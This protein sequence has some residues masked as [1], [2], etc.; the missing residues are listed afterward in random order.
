M[1]K[2]KIHLEYVFEKV[3]KNILWNHLT[4]PTGLSDWFADDVSVNGSNIFIFSWNKAT[5]EA[6]CLS[7]SHLSYIRFKWLDDEDDTYYFE[8]RIHTVELTGDTALEITDFVEPDEKKETINLW[9][10]QI[11]I[12]RRTLGI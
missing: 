6:E 11:K 1:E 9:D 4:T 12:L 2:E 5:Q 8:F 10:S 3:S 7:S